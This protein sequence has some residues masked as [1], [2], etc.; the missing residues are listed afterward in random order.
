M[1]T[2]SLTLEVSS[3]PSFTRILLIEDREEDAYL[4]QELLTDFPAEQ[5]QLTWKDTLKDGLACLH[6]NSFE[7]ILL[8][9]SLP[10][11]RGLVTLEQVHL[12][13][14]YL[15]VVVLTGFE[16][17][18]LG[19]KAMQQGAQDYLL[20][21]HLD[22]EI[23]ARSLSYAIE[24]KRL[25]SQLRLMQ[26]LQSLGH[27]ASVLSRDFE[28]CL[29]LIK[30]NARL[31]SQAIPP[32]SKGHRYLDEIAKIL[33]YA[34]ELNEHLLSYA[35]KDRSNKGTLQTQ[36]INISALAEETLRLFKT[37]T[38]QQIHCHW[39]LANNLPL[40]DGDPSLL[41][42][43]FFNLLLNAREAIDE[44]EGEICVTTG[45][46]YAER[47]FLSQC[48]TYDP[49]TEGIYIYLEVYDTGCGISTQTMNKLFEPFFTTKDKGRGFGLAAVI[50]AIHSHH[51][52]IHFSS[53]L[54]KGTCVGVLFPCHTRFAYL[55][56]EQRVQRRT[57]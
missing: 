28:N 36:R 15:P 47:S 55:R 37:H 41:H 22:S 26:R 29:K 57:F 35:V 11:S 50:S 18:T 27:F 4:L 10:D 13:A 24:R 12:V 42:Q 32:D 34:R 19:L 53:L 14:P 49:L 46:L 45:L 33:E 6:D 3:T 43:M 52:A 16:D 39:N 2:T 5:F 23:L 48:L 30:S 56:E 25:E 31:V 8:D 1:V 21:H 7:V 38:C 44:K 17:E 9:L 54:G 51:G 20:K 40:M